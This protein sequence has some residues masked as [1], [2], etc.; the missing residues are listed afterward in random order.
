M[1]GATGSVATGSSILKQMLPTGR[2]RRHKYIPVGIKILLSGTSAVGATLVTHPFDVV[3]VNLQV[4]GVSAPTPTAQSPLQM[5]AQSMRDKG[6][7]FLYSGVGAAVLRQLSYGSARLAIFDSFMTAYETKDGAPPSFDRKVM[8]SAIA[9]GIGAIIGNPADMTLV[10]MA[11]DSRLPPD[12]RRNYQNVFDAL[13]RIK[14]EE[15]VL[16]WWKGSTPTV[17]RCVVVN[18][19]Q[20]TTYSQA[21]QELLN[22]GYIKEDGLKCHVVSSMI[23]GLVATLAT[24]P[25]DVVKTRIQNMKQGQN[26]GVI[27]CLAQIAR[28]EG[29][30]A[31]WRGFLPAYARMGPQT[32]IMF[33]LFETLK[34][35]YQELA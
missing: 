29:V 16:A 33:I 31:L 24:Q 23:A 12:Q 6:P 32:T 25:V 1:E 4:S 14:K 17:A 26:M 11:A 13:S 18:V 8:F 28:T 35:R 3:K 34:K 19:S 20:L 21:K 5:I 7:K 2:G 30:P 22:R 15:G 10:R 27:S 9:G